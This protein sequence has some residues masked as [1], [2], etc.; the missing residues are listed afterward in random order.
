M[1]PNQEEVQPL[2]P[3]GLTGARR[4]AKSLNCARALAAYDA[5]SDMRT[6]A[7]LIASVP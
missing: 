1:S 6:R 2:S 5:P 4:G 3:T 7:K